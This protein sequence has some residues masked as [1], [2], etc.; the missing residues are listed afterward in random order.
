MLTALVKK[1]L[2]SSTISANYTP[3]EVTEIAR[4]AKMPKKQKETLIIESMR[5]Q[6]PKTIKG[7]KD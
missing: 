1:L 7:L 3:D 4:I 6:K 5:A 2:K